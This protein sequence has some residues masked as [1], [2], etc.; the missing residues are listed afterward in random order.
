ML[1]S[2]PVLSAG[3]FTARTGRLDRGADHYQHGRSKCRKYK[4]FRDSSHK[5]K[6][7]FHG[8]I[9]EPSRIPFRVI[10]IGDVGRKT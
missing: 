4:H 7:T 5:D 2:P 10:S 3:L 1:K 9:S 8:T 6:N